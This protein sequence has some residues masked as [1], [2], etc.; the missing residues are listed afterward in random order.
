MMIY[1]GPGQ[2]ESHEWEHLFC[3]ELWE[4]QKKRKDVALGLK[5][6]WGST[7]RQCNTEKTESSLPSLLAIAVCP[8]ICHLTTLSSIFLIFKM[9]VIIADIT[10]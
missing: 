7:D 4:A 1:Q 5:C 3:S 2:G 9:K 6:E 8:C 10:Y